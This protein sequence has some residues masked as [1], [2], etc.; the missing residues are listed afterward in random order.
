[1]FA[2]LLAGARDVDGV[3]FRWAVVGGGD[4]PDQPGEDDL[5]IGERGRE[6]PDRHKAGIEQPAPRVLAVPD[7]EPDDG[8]PRG[9]VTPTMRIRQA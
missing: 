1:M 3:A 6:R 8:A 9:W 7:P 5:T 2:W 4:L